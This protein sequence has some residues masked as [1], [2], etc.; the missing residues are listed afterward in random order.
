[1]QVKCLLVKLGINRNSPAHPTAWESKQKH[2]TLVEHHD[3][4]SGSQGDQQKRVKSR[5]E[6]GY[7]TDL[8]IDTWKIAPLSR[9]TKQNSRLYSRRL[10]TA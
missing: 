10:V 5:K 7:E 2:T 6:Q 4:Y 1:M 9:V 8:R 3:S